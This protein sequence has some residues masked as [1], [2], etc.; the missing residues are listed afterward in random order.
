M[1]DP[2]ED[3]KLKLVGC[4]QFLILNYL[5]H[6]SAQSQPVDLEPCKPFG[7][8]GIKRVESIPD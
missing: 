7:A 8:S 3:V 6:E 2:I 4:C 1:Q 5:R